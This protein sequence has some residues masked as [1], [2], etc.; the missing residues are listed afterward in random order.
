MA[1]K[2]AAWWAAIAVVA[3]LVSTVGVFGLIDCGVPPWLEASLSLVAAPG[4]F[5]LLLWVPVLKR[6][7]LTQGEWVTVPDPFGFLMITALYA[8]IVFAV[9]A[10]LTRVIER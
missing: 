7:G 9:V 1:R 6:I 5:A 2:R 8:L 10:L 4:V 3:Y